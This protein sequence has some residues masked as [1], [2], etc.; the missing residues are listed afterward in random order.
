MSMTDPIADMLTRIRNAQSA[1]HDE[2]HVPHSRLKEAVAGVLKEEGYIADFRAVGSGV[3]KA[4][5]ISLRY[6][7][8]GVPVVS[9]LKR[10]SRPGRRA[11]FGAGE[12]PRVLDGLG[13]CILSTSH[14]V[15]SDREARR[16]KVGG[17]VLCDIW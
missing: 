17:E 3:T 15:L 2:A 16:Q 9:G 14:G 1:H 4:L 13:I 11:Y 5:Q 12:I 8:A 10:V 6:T 7:E